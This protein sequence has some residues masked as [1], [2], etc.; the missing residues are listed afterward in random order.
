M[1]TTVLMELEDFTFEAARGQ[2]FV[3]ALRAACP[4]RLPGALAVRVKGQ[5]LGLNAPV[6]GPARL[7]LLTYQD[8]EG[9]RVYER[10]LRFVFLLAVRQLMPEARVRLEYS[11]GNGVYAEIR[12]GRPLSAQMVRRIE[13]RMRELVALDLPFEKQRLTRDEAIRY[14]EQDGQLDKVQLLKYRPYEH[15]QM[16]ACG[17]MKEY[18]YGEMVPSTG[19]VPVFQLSFYLPGLVLGLPDPVQPNRPSPFHD[20]PKLMRTFAESARWANILA[21]ENAADLNALTARKQLRE[22]IR[23][24]EALHERSIFTIADQFASSGARLILIAGPS[25]SGK[26]TFARR[27]SIALKVLGKRPVSVSLDDYYLDRDAI[28][29]DE[30]GQR[31]LERL[32]TLDVKL[33]G[34]H[35][36][37]LL[38]GEEVLM[39]RFDF[40]TGKRAPD[41]HLL[42]VAPDQPI[43]VEG[44]HGL[45]DQLTALVPRELKFKIYVSALTTLNLDD[46]N[47][48]RT[49]DARLLRRM[50]RDFHFRGASVEV[51]MGMWDSVRRGEHNYIFPFQ[52]DAD[53][54]FNS[55]LVY[56]LPVIKKYVY[57]MLAQVGPE[58][59]HYTQARRLVKFLNYFLVA[60][61]EDEIPLN[62]ILREFIGGCCFY[63]EQP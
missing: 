44:I 8:A 10:S 42:R 27:L 40:L 51:T 41:G 23:V 15:F 48:I 25:S 5:T 62:S 39:P 55:S 2:S 56:E 49:T 11:I 50:V 4:E 16:Y 61:V 14:F 29:L 54:I 6:E 17:E 47:R 43:V 26:T 12:A 58:S 21:C 36:V 46:H 7:S 20:Q 9:R 30:H 59:P 13:E 31:D 35:L 24:N 34:D 28:P 63:R 22:F 52:E 3:E 18:F 19:Y 38:Q 53:V 33:L 32:D 1:N 45:N 60:E 57:P 37:R